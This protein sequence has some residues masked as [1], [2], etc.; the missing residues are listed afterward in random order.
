MV[1]ASIIESYYY[2]AGRNIYLLQSDKDV[3]QAVEM[4]NNRKLMHKL[5]S[6]EPDA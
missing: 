2:D 3:Q 5:L 6:G 1:E 4:M